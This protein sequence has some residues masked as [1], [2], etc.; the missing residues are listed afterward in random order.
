MPFKEEVIYVYSCDTCKER[1]SSRNDRDAYRMALDCEFKGTPQ[2]H[3]FKK[4]ILN[5]GL[6]I[7]IGYWDKRTFEIL[8]LHFEKRTHKP[9]YCV[10]IIEPGSFCDRGAIFSVHG[11]DI[12]LTHI[13]DVVQTGC[14]EATG[15]ME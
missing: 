4:G 7:P 15:L 10:K 8:D 9:L 3:S 1:F 6:K 14:E 2:V 13:F 5:A 12:R 11:E